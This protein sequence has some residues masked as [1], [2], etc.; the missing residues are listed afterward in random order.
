MTTPTL[1]PPT[2]T[3]AAN[4]DTRTPIPGGR[5]T[6]MVCRNC[7]RTQELELAY[8]CPACFG[9]LEVAYD[10]SVVA[11][12]LTKEAIAAR[13]PGIWRYIELLPVE[14]VPVRSL[15]VGSTPL[16]AA[17]RLGPVLD[18]ERLRSLAGSR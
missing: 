16:L 7:G 6:G 5:I 3:P 17:D 15:P 1:T 13:A 2:S 18:V 9:P 14:T 10:L 4:A 11:G 8:V 12:T